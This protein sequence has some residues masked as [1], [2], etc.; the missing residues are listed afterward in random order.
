MSKLMQRSITGLVFGIVVIGLVAYSDET[1]RVFCC[2]VGGLAMLEY[3]RMIHVRPLIIS[4][5]GSGL[6]W[7]LTIYQSDSEKVM[8]LVLPL[9]F[10]FSTWSLIALWK[11]D[12]LNV[13]NRM[14]SASAL[15]YFGFNTTL[16]LD[17]LVNNPTFSRWSLLGIICIIWSSDSFAYLVGSKIGKTK[18]FPSV[19][20]NKTWE[21]TL[22]GAFFAILTAMGVWYF[23][24]TK[25]L[26][27]WSGT[28]LIVFIFGTY[29]DLVESSIKRKF[30]VKDSGN[31][32]PGH[33]GFFDRFDSFIFVWPFVY[34]VFEILGS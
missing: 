34:L 2:L 4:F 18:L 20:P 9:A 8:R 23:T 27:F 7:Y 29:G 3:N 32:L 13:H 21:G 15:L 31:I 5:I 30:G 28:G 1:A 17:L 12:M 19:S 26:F 22:G 33:G 10:L 16:V 6:L 14:P 11:K 24:E 25:S